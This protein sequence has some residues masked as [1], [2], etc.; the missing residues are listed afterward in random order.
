[1]R[2]YAGLKDGKIYHET[3]GSDDGDFL[4]PSLYVSKEVAERE[5]AEFKKF[6]EIRRVEVKEIQARE[7]D[8]KEHL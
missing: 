1:M 3:I 4:S 8:N 5:L 7:S 2:Y 6:D